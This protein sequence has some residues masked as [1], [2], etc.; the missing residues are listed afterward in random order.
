MRQAS[1]PSKFWDGRILDWEGGR[2]DG[3]RKLSIGPGEFLAGVLSAPTRDRQN[4]S[5]ELLAPFL[6]GCSVL[7]LGCGT[8][9]L[10]Q[11]L[12]DAGCTRYLGVDHSSVAID[13]ARQRYAGT[14]AA[15]RMDFEV[16]SAAK[17][18]PVGFDI[19]ISLGALDWLSD[20]ELR[21]L[22][23]NQKSRQFLHTFSERR[24]TVLQLCHRLGRNMDAL[25]RPGA[26]RPRYMAA[27]QLIALMP[28]SNHPQVVVYRDDRLRFATFLSSLP[29][30]DGTRIALPGASDL[31]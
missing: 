9:R 23:R 11:R 10:A 29:L 17:A 26:V 25:L 6:A 16:C 1:D 28:P 3:S 15:Q 24:N 20:E 18:S 22:F 14:D 2:Y 30:R 8:G 5:V 31:T 7:E 4:L 19:I 12:L 21:E 27:D 13:H